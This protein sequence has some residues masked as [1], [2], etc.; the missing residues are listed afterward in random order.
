MGKH[1]FQRLPQDPES[2]WAQTPQN[3][4]HVERREGFVL[5]L[6]PFCLLSSTHTL[7]SGS[8]IARPGLSWICFFTLGMKLSW[9][10]TSVHFAITL[11]ILQKGPKPQPK[12]RS[13]KKLWPNTFQHTFLTNMWPAERQTF[14]PSWSYRFS[15][16]VWRKRSPLGKSSVSPRHL[17]L[18]RMNHLLEAP[19]SS[20]ATNRAQTEI[21]TNFFMPGVKWRGSYTKWQYHYV[22]IQT[23][24]C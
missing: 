16:A 4:Q 1:I 20:L 19:L 24:Y 18:G 15:L 3:I 5:A 23:I 17:F 13:P 7:L 10:S 11:L 12:Q 2:R 22:S 21:K 9:L 6:G 14:H 8:S